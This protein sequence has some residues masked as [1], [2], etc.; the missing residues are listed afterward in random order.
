MKTPPPIKDEFQDWRV[1]DS[2]MHVRDMGAGEPVVFLHGNPTSSFLWR[3]VVP[4][5]AGAGYRCLAIDLIGMGNSGKP[6]IGYR[7]T[8]H[9]TYLDAL[10]DTLGCETSPVLV[11]HD[12]GAVLA[13]DR[14][15]RRPGNV[16]AVAICEGHIHPVQTWAD[17]GDGAE[18]FQQLRA[19]ETGEAMA[20]DQNFFVEEVLPGGMN[21]VLT[22]AE[23]QSYR[24]PYPDAASRAPVLAWLREIPVEGYPANMVQTVTANQH[25]IADPKMD[26]LLIRGEPGAVIGTN[27][28]AWCR[29]H[30]QSLTISKVGPGLHFLPEDRPQQIAAALLD[31]L[32]NLSVP[33]SSE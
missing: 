2:F 3:E 19:P 11:G 4:V 22:D 32:G 24:E 26:T 21:R 1:L 15:R 33:S 8:D 23:M 18:M 27:E 29:D 20:L 28:V 10:L 13:L 25:V 6:D 17:M 30:G 14:A 7:F 16:R 9:A 12:W 31:W 5:I